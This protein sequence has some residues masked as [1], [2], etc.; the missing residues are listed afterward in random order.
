MFDETHWTD[1]KLDELEQHADEY[2]KPVI[3]SVINVM[4]PF[5][6]VF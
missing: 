3:Q 4:R 5:W 1:R 2:N 6:N